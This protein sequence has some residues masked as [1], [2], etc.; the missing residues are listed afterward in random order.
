MLF[1]STCAVWGQSPKWSAVK[2]LRW[3]AKGGGGGGRSVFFASL[4]CIRGSLE[5]LFQINCVHAQACMYM[6]SQRHAW[7]LVWVMVVGFCLYCFFKNMRFDIPDISSLPR[8]LLGD[9]RCGL[10]ALSS[11]TGR[12]S[13]IESLTMRSFLTAVYQAFELNRYCQNMNVLTRNP[14]LFS[15]LVFIF[16]VFVML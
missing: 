10:G 9:Q 2:F 3:T 12:C 8:F 1:Y 14:S 13:N 5:G 11:L 4:W 15:C 7:G 6:L 16:L